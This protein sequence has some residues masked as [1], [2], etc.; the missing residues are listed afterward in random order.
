MQNQSKPITTNKNQLNHMQ[1]QLKP[2]KN[3]ENN[4]DLCTPN[5][6][7]LRLIKTD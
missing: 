6:N 5:K 2:I 7:Q 4:K 1:T 3:N